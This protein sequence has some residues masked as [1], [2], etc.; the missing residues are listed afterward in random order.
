MKP[1]RRGLNVDDLLQVE[2]HHVGKLEILEE[3]VEHLL[4]GQHELEVVLALARR[5]RLRALAAVA[6]CGLGN[7]VARAEHPCCRA[8]PPRAGRHRGARWKRRLADALRAG[9]TTTCSASTS[10]ILPDLTCSLMA[11]L[12]LARGPAAGIAAGCRG[13]CPSG[14]RRRSMKFGIEVP[15]R[16]SPPCSPACTSR[17]AA[18]PAARV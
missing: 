15:A 3:Q 11:A 12:Q 7:A 6:G 5:R 9:S 4:A 10:A 18:A 8:A 14:L 16:V 17:P 13:S 2:L 1:A